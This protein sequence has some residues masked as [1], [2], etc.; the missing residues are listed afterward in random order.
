MQLCFSGESFSQS[1]LGGAGFRPSTV[2]LHGSKHELKTRNRPAC[3]LRQIDRCRLV[4]RAVPRDP[5]GFQEIL[6]LVLE[7]DKGWGGRGGGSLAYGCFFL[8]G[9]CLVCVHVFQGP[10]RKTNIL[11][12]PDG[13][14]SKSGTKMAPWQM[15]PK[16]KPRLTPAL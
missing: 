10:N 9:T 8:E 5:L 4:R 2:S 3:A 6:C 12:V 7:V 11:E 1:F 15:K 14:G 16:T 13:C